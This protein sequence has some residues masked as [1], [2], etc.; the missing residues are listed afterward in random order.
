MKADIDRPEW[1]A[2]REP[3]DRQRWMRQMQTAKDNERRAAALIPDHPAH[4]KALAVL[5]ESV[6]SRRQ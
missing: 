2:N 3:A 6:A 4:L 5:E 1:I